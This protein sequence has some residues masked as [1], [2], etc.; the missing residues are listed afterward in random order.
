M[1]QRG[2]LLSIFLASC[3]I[4]VVTMCTTISELVDDGDAVAGCLLLI[5]HY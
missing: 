4:T 1:D 3:L 2:N 5:Y